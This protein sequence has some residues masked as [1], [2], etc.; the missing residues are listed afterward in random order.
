MAQGLAWLAF[1]DPAHEGTDTFALGFGF[2]RSRRMDREL[3]VRGSDGGSPCIPT[4][5][6]ARG[7]EASA[8]YPVTGRLVRHGDRILN[9]GGGWWG[10][11]V[12]T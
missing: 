10:Y 6:R 2:E 11:L 5:L 7:C 9:L 8:L 1:R 12:L 3:H 4:R